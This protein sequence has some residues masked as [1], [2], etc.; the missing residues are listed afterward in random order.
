MIY[1][2]FHVEWCFTTSFRAWKVVWLTIINVFVEKT[3][4]QL[5][6]CGQFFWWGKTKDPAKTTN[7]S[8]VIDTLCHIML[9][10]SPWSR[11]ELTTS[12][13]LDTDCIGSCKF[14]Y[15][16][17]RVMK[18]SLVDYPECI[19]RKTKMNDISSKT[20]H[21]LHTKQNK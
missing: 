20:K 19:C 8:Q 2:F 12:V 16:T 15:H 6:R 4:F 1:T 21:R 10:T 17:I 5:Y 3:I 7:L 14:N 9:Y 11:F 18:S 13:V